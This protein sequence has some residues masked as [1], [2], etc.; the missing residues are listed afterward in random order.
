MPITITPI[1][2]LTDNYVWLIIDNNSRT[3]LAVDPG[4][5]KPILDYLQQHS[6]TLAGILVTHHHW[7]HTN[8]IIDLKDLSD[9]PVYGAM[10]SNNANVTHRV[11]ENDTIDFA[12]LQLQIIAIPGHT[13]DHTAY[14]SPGILFSGDTL[15]AAGCGRVFEGTMPQMF[16]TLQTLAALPDDTN[17]YCGHEYT[18]K[19]L[20]FA[21]IVEPN[22]LAIKN[23]IE[24][25]KSLRNSGLPSLPSQLSDEKQTNPFL[26]C[27]AAEI[28][29]NVSAH[30]NKTLSSAVDVFTELRKWKDNF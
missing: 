28:I 1:P 9:I 3:A 20:T 11:S 8:G 14:Y 18:L 30:A 26:R 13:L 5:A 10:N 24:N 7:D 27:D 12:S 25:V 6:L 17:I 4:E 22:N 15:F 21:E 2:A 16:A 23:R 29:A 19:N